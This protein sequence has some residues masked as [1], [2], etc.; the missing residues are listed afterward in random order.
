MVGVCSV[1]FLKN[2]VLRNGGC[3]IYAHDENNAN[4][5]LKNKEKK[6]KETIILSPKWEQISRI[7]AVT[8]KPVGP[9][10]PVGTDLHTTKTTLRNKGISKIPQIFLIG[11]NINLSKNQ[12]V[13]PSFQGRHLR[14]DN[15]ILS[16]CN[17]K[18]IFS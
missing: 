14:S 2:Q 15:F 7:S 17:G 6:R 9:I 16:R 5:S 3:I 11:D 4:L 8:I 18:V 12:Y 13:R 10:F 1:L